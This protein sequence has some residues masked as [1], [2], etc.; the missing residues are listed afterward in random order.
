MLKTENLL[1][2]I[3]QIMYSLNQVK[4]KLLKVCNEFNKVIKQ[5]G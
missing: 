5:N 1:N 3:C 4:K 2:D